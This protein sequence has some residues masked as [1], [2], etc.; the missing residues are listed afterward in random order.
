MIGLPPVREALR[1]WCGLDGLRLHD[2]RHSF[3]S[4]GVAFGDSLPI[5]DALLGHADSATTSRYTH[6][7]ADPLKAAADRIA[8][9]IAEAMKG[10]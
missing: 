9:F 5:I 7:P 2:L 4:V 1:D 6:L 8:G 10:G 3:A